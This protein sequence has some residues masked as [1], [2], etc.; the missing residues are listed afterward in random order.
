MMMR[1]NDHRY[2]N[3]KWSI[4][5]LRDK[6]HLLGFLTTFI[7]L[8]LFIDS[9]LIYFIKNELQT[10]APQLYPFLGITFSTSIILYSFYSLIVK[11][12]NFILYD[13]FYSHA[14]NIKIVTIDD[15]LSPFTPISQELE[16]IIIGRNDNQK[17]KKIDNQLS[18]KDNILFF[19]IRKN[20]DEDFNEE[21][22]EERFKPFLSLIIILFA[23][24]EKRFKLISVVGIYF[25]IVGF[26]FTTYMLLYI[27]VIANHYNL[28]DTWIAIILIFFLLYWYIWTVY[29]A[30]K[31]VSIDTYLDNINQEIRRPYLRKEI[32]LGDS[33]QQIIDAFHEDNAIYI[34]DYHLDKYQL[35]DDKYLYKNLP[36]RRKLVKKSIGIL[37]TVLISAVFFLFLEISNNVVFTQTGKIHEESIQKLKEG[38]YKNE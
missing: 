23:L 30:V 18:L 16:K 35:I 31:M 29:S 1:E 32:Q 6:K 38:C 13:I 34:Y 11:N 9:S 22:R 5:N 27:N 15:N 26:L 33:Y 25:T 17:S 20:R 10:F 28:S 7:I 3:P 21:E 12:R 36:K 14:L 37:L 2:T 8:I 19:W 4:Q 24:K